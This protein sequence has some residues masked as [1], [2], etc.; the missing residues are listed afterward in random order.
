M[1][2]ALVGCGKQEAPAAATNKS[3]TLMIYMIGSDLEAK[4]AAGTNDFKEMAESGIDLTKANVVV[5]AGGSK[6][7]HND[8]VDAEKHTL[9]NLTESGFEV[10]ETKERASMVE[11]QCLQDFVNY[12]YENYP[13]ENYSLILW[14]H[15]AGPVE[16]Y[17]KDLFYEDDTLTL[18]EMKIALDGTP[19][20]KDEKLSFVGFDA[21]LMSSA[22]LVCLFDNYADYLVASQEIEPSMG[23]NYSF[24]KDL[25]VSDTEA[26]I[27]NISKTYMDA[28]LEY[29]EEWDYDDRDTTLACMKLSEAANLEKAINSLFSVATG[30][31]DIKYNSFA[32]SRVN[33]RALGRATTG[34]EYDLVDVYDMA[35]QLSSIYPDE[36]K[37]IKDAIDKIVIDN[38][39]NT[40]GC[41][42]LSIYYPFYNKG[43]YEKS[44]KDAYGKLGVLSDYASYLGE[45]ASIWLSS[46]GEIA[47]GVATPEEESAG[48]YSLQLTDE[49]AESFAD[50]KYYILVQEGAELYTKVFSSGDVELNG[51][52]L[53]A[54]FDGQILYAKT[55]FGEYMLPVT[56]EHD[57]VGDTTRYSVYVNLS[58]DSPMYWDMD[59]E[60]YE[61]KNEGYRFY[62]AA[63]TK[64]KEISK[65][66]LVPGNME[67]DS[68]TLMSGKVDDADLSQW[69][70]Y[71]FPNERHRYITR[72][73][74]G[75]IKP[76]NEWLASSF[77][78]WYESN[79]GDGLEFVFDYCAAGRYSIIFEIEDTKGNKYCSE[80]IEIETDKTLETPDGKD[81]ITVDWT[82]G[83][84][85]KLFSENNVT[86]SLVAKEDYA[87]KGYGLKVENNNDF[88]IIV[89]AYEYIGYNGN[90]FCDEGYGSGV[91]V[92]ANSTATSEYCFSYGVP[93]DYNLM[94][95]LES[96]ELVINAERYE[97]GK[98]IIYK[99]PVSVKLS[100]K[101]TIIP[102]PSM[103]EYD[104]FDYPVKSLQAKEQT[105]FSEEG[106]KATLLGVGG[107]EYGGALKGVIKLENTTDKTKYITIEGLIFDN[108]YIENS[109]GTITVPAGCI[110]YD[111]IYLSEDD[112]DEY[113]ITS[114]SSMSVQIKFSDF[115]T[116]EGGGGFGRSYIYPVSLSS[117]GSGCSFPQGTTV[118]YND[119]GVKI[120]LHELKVSDYYIDWYITVSNNSSED[121]YVSAEN[122]MVD[123]IP[124]N[125][126][127]VAG[128]VTAYSSGG[129]CPVGTKTFMIFNADNVGRD[130]EIV[131]DIVAFDFEKEKILWQS[132][133]P[134]TITYKK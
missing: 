12:A 99:Q 129:K 61:L 29:Y 6:K 66:A 60:K 38:T 33:T 121:I 56:A 75:T 31:I 22:E 51:N 113:M 103:W 26:L 77:F 4:G 9:L 34:S 1:A 87:G 42:G 36:A 25:G 59:A 117:K 88:K 68:E 35:E 100:D 126:M 115:L 84:A 101:T 114:P 52:T 37:A 92:D 123:G 47:E 20:A 15:G 19:F 55:D 7:W 14:D 91:Y 81:I 44:W 46:D 39:T 130:L 3:M 48:S 16:G 13:A 134:V 8:I 106:V 107:D 40:T 72:Y 96:I 98:T 90:V 63:D 67:L 58:N 89:D 30:E 57:T 27:K 23:W 125:D 108:I 127:L 85:V 76:V 112:M 32:S 80:P 73:E 93:Q 122:V 131:F 97:G 82:N 95:D 116:L 11:A 78:S 53:S 50:A 5:Y 110:V 94:T 120:S 43:Y 65:S 62:L 70:E 86:V 102:P 10:V 24:L 128:D 124:T 45:Y 83:D 105:L 74:N 64:T 71:K 49:Q 132:E 79:I 118:L 41:C 119:N 21:C 133:K 17:G 18:P 109:A 104:S 111:Q 54:N 2:L 28:C 69:N